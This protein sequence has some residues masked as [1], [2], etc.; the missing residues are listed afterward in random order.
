MKTQQRCPA[1][2]YVH[3]HPVIQKEK[4]AFNTECV[5]SYFKIVNFNGTITV[6]AGMR[7][8]GQT[9]EDQEM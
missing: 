5:A 8:G 1:S 3:S 7:T 2:K 9:G 4:E 6:K